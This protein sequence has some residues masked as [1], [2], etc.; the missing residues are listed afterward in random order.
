[1]IQFNNGNEFK[2]VFYE[3]CDNYGIKA[4]PMTTYNPRSN[5]IIER[6]HQVLRDNVATFEL[7]NQELPEHDSFGAF[8]SAASWAIRSTFHTT[9]QAT[10]GQL[11]FGQDMI[12][13]ATSTNS[14][15]VGTVF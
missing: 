6:I 13:P 12:K 8:I 2:S 3:T 14:K 9:L 4:K 5:G 15:V 7:L 10:T 1:M 11:V